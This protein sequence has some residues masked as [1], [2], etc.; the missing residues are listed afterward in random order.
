MHEIFDCLIDGWFLIFSM[1][2]KFY[3]YLRL[4]MIVITK[5]YFF[6][7]K[8]HKFSNFQA[9]SWCCTWY[10]LV[11]WCYISPYAKWKWKMLWTPTIGT[12]KWH[13]SYCK[14]CHFAWTRATKKCSVYFWVLM[15]KL[16]RDK[17]ICG[18]KVNLHNARG[19][20]MTIIRF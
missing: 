9:L 3:S 20:V 18:K 5:Y 4:I 6:F 13:S 10:E 11:V 15:R 7:L 19:T 8:F 1:S 14:F 12:L 16:N 2:T 17:L